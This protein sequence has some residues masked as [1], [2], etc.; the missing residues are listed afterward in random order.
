M[1]CRLLIPLPLPVHHLY[2]PL[3]SAYPSP[4]YQNCRGRGSKLPPPFRIPWIPHHFPASQP[5]NASFDTIDRP[6][7]PKDYTEWVLRAPRFISSLPTSQTA[8]K[9]FVSLSGYSFTL[10]CH[11]RCPS[12]LSPCPPALLLLAVSPWTIFLWKFNLDLHQIPMC[13]HGHLRN[14]CQYQ[15]LP[16]S[17]CYW[18]SSTHS[19]PPVLTTVNPSLLISLLT[20]SI[21]YKWFKTRLPGERHPVP[22][23][24]ASCQTTY[25]L[26][27]LAWT[28]WFPSPTCLTSSSPTATSEFSDPSPLSPCPNVLSRKPTH[29]PK[30]MTSLTPKLFEEPSCTVVRFMTVTFMLFCKATLAHWKPYDNNY[31]FHQKMQSSRNWCLIF[32]FPFVFLPGGHRREPGAPWTSRGQEGKGPQSPPQ[33]DGGAHP[34]WDSV[35]PGS[36]GGGHR[37]S[38]SPS[39]NPLLLLSSSRWLFHFNLQGS[40]SVVFFSVVSLSSSNK[41]KPQSV[42]F[43][44]TG[45]RASC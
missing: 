21:D 9:Q 10:S 43:S 3:Q 15:A 41:K 38:V 22:W 5:S 19:S 35:W 36:E 39:A 44:A 16:Y 6:F 25:H 32:F 1:H 42:W 14:Y 34:Q 11:T 13:F 4:Q 40:F 7:S 17:I 33:P 20:P 24:Q 2:E 31:Y 45:S 27:S 23:T 37:V 30:P 28:A 8:R 12:G 29:L 18:I 26:K